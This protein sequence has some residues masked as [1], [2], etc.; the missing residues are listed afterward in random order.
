L[1]PLS[2]MGLS[3]NIDK[4]VSTMKIKIKDLKKVIK[5]VSKDVV[6]QSNAEEEKS[7][8]SAD[9]YEFRVMGDTVEV[10]F[11][12]EDMQWTSLV[13]FYMNGDL[14]DGKDAIRNLESVILELL[15]SLNF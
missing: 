2:A 11:A 12:G 6:D 1:V 13:D 10:K 5:E 7:T 15:V 8:F 14:G 9:G 3:Q 4:E